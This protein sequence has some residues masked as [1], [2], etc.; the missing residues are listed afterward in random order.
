M[1]ITYNY[2]RKPTTE[3]RIFVVQKGP[4]CSYSFF[5]PILPG[6]NI[7]NTN[8]SSNNNNMII[9]SE[10]QQLRVQQCISEVIQYKSLN[11]QPISNGTDITLDLFNTKIRKYL[12][13][14]KLC[15]PLFLS[16]FLAQKWDDLLTLNK[17]FTKKDYNYTYINM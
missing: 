1:I 4:Y 14:H 6:H 2:L 8:N 16:T 9:R 17:I 11:Y 12:F 10:M 3:K 13:K 7:N 15:G 5:V